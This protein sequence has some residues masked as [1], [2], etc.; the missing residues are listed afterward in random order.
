MLRSVVV[1]VA[2]LLI[3]SP[4]RA[5][6]KPPEPPRA[7]EERGGKLV[8]ST[9]EKGDRIPDF[10]TCGYL[11]GG[12][13]I[14]DVPVRVVVAPVDGD[15]TARV[16]AAI[17]HVASL[18]PAENGFRGAVLL[19]PGRFEIAGGLRI[20]ASG[21]V[22]R[23]SGMGEGGTVLVATGHDR[24]TL[25]TVAGR[26]DRKVDSAAVRMTDPYVPVHATRLRVADATKFKVG[27]S[28]IIRRPCTA[29]WIKA[30]GMESMGGE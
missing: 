19:Q 24:R 17:N 10:S 14:P 25:I 29:E 27:D 1:V 5:Q 6:P 23:G 28:V 8:Y 20:A 12:V 7:V 4:L 2:T 9:S 21:V 15:D 16:Q 3:A 26:A 18:E 11:G 30:L 22:L 13:P